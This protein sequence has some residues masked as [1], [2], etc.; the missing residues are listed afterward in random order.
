MHAQAVDEGA[1]INNDPAAA[2]PGNELPQVALRTR[3][4]SVTRAH[5]LHFRFQ[6]A[7]A[8]TGPKAAPPHLEARLA[9]A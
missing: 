1:G 4:N 3:P 6:A 9:T 2:T 7:T 5:N 8:T